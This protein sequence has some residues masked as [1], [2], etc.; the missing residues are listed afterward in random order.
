MNNLTIENRNNVLLISIKR[1]SKMNALN[2]ELLGELEQC[3]DHVYDDYN[4]KGAVITGKGEKAFAAGA[5]IAEFSNFTAAQGKKMSENGHRIF[6]KIEQSP[7]P[8]IA[9]VNGFA[10]GGGCELAMACHM[11]LASPNA[12]FGQPE[13][14]LGIIPGYGGTQRLI[15]L[16]GKGKAMELLTTADMIKADEAL[17]LGLVNHVYELNE[18]VDKAIELIEK[19]ASKAP[20]AIAKTIAAVNAYF[21]KSKNGMQTEI[22]LFASCMETQDFKEGTAAFIEKR[23]A[24]FK[25]E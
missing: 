2:I 20:L 17:R 6:N 24:N 12:R 9:A 16:I 18:L 23:S 7:K 21:D 14:N 10:L 19:I 22:E 13:I 11:R 4:I 3:I 8:I 1:E 5:D 15:Q 25:G